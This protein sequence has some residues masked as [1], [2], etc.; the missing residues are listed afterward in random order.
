MTGCEIGN[1]DYNKAFEKLIEKDMSPEE[2]TKILSEATNFGE[3]IKTSMENNTLI[4][5]DISKTNVDAI[6]SLLTSTDASVQKLVATTISQNLDK[7]DLLM[8]K[9]TLNDDTAWDAI[10]KEFGYAEWTKLPGPFNAGKA[11]D[12]AYLAKYLLA[13]DER[14]MRLMDRV[15]VA[16]KEHIAVDTIDEIANIVDVESAK[17]ILNNDQKLKTIYGAFTSN[18]AN[19][20]DRAE[21]K[22]IDSYG[23]PKLEWV[24]GIG[25]KKEFGLISPDG[26]VWN[27]TL[28]DGKGGFDKDFPKEVF[29]EDGYGTKYVFDI[30][31]Y[32][33]IVASGALNNFTGIDGAQKTQQLIVDMVA[34][35]NN[36]T[37]IGS[38]C[39]GTEQQEGDGL[40][41]GGGGGGG[42]GGYGGSSGYSN[43]S[44]DEQ[45]TL[46]IECN[47]STA[48]VWNKGTGEKIG[49]TNTAIDMEK[50]NYTIEVKAP[51]YVTRSMVITIGSYAVS[52]TINLSKI[53]PSISTFINGIGGIQNL[54]RT[55]YLYLYC[56]Y[57]MRTTSEY[58]WKVFADSID[59]V[60]ATSLPT[61][62]SK[63]DV[64]YVYYLVTGDIASATALVEAGKVT[65]LAADGT[66]IEEGE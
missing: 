24:N 29:V 45:T 53:G 50:G 28:N 4:P 61:M 43:N 55:K 40:S 41:M 54:T 38:K 52:K 1:W 51:G 20:F 63:E 47:V 31:K 65:L 18:Y 57:K 46:Y 12:S 3:I 49:E 21:I 11:E 37:C 39:G 25:E 27:P 42:S 10:A 56:I 59:T 8:L 44:S 6:K 7:D 60:S 30:M 17:K 14:A 48:A 26:F 23:E 5:P 33:E 22:A 66:P 9:K 15:E 34:D 35:E 2:A 13:G 64:L 36:W 16:G 19:M 32:A 62:I 58:T